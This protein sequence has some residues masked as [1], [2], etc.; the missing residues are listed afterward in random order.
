MPSAQSSKAFDVTQGFGGDVL[1]PVSMEDAA[2]RL[3]AYCT[4]VGSGWATHD[5]A[6][7]HLRRAGLFNAG[8]S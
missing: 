8:S 1:G 6:A 4:T 2:K 3:L 7:A 5:L